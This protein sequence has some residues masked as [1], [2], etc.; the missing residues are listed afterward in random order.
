M[1]T[2]DVNDNALVQGSF[3]ANLLQEQATG[4]NLTGHY[5][6]AGYGR[7]GEATISTG[8]VITAEYLNAIT[9]ALDTLGAMFFWDKA[10]KSDSKAYDVTGPFHGVLFTFGTGSNQRGGAYSIQ[11]ITDSGA[12]NSTA[13]KAASDV[14]ISAS[15]GVITIANSNTSYELRY[16]IL[17][18]SGSLTDHVVPD[19]STNNR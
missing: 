4:M 1:D 8:D 16:G 3:V 10:A 17:I 11:R 9:G 5:P 19:E 15:D 12:I 13:I 7:A 2:I 6:I 18:W 14:T